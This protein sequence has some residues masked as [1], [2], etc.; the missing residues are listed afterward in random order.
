M[1]ARD[2]K[3]RAVRERAFTTVV[4]RK[5]L[6][7][8]SIDELPGLTNPETTAIMLALCEAMGM[9]VHFIA[10]AFGFQKNIPFPDDAALQALIEKQWAV[11]RQFGASIGFHSG[12]GK[13]AANYQVMGRVTGGRL[14]IKTSGRYTYEMGVALARSNDPAD[15]ALWRDWY[16][17]TVELALQG[18]FSADPTERKMARVFI[19]DALNGAGRP[20]DVFGSA[21]A[22]RAAVEALPASPDHMFWFEYNF[23]FV[24]AA[25]GEAEKEALGDHTPRGYRQRAR[26]YAISSEGRLNFARGVARYIVFLAQN[27]GLV[28][29]ERCAAARTLL[30]RYATMEQ[31]LAD[32]SR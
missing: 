6:R 26:F 8:L 11:C 30:D 9:P 28:P 16:R 10:P 19:A 29:A 1:K 32:I 3:Y 18:A 31:L 17:F 20:T 24:L 23:L 27:T 15:Q 7:E 25:G 22:T 12:S 5:Y 14:E 2:D 13:S 4:G 21:A